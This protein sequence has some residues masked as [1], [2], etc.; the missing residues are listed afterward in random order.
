MSH[1]IYN[2][3]LDGEYGVVMASSS[4][5]RK[6]LMVVTTVKTHRFHITSKTS[7]KVLHNGQIVHVSDKIQLA[8]K[9]YNGIHSDRMPTDS[10]KSPCSKGG[11]QPLKEPIGTESAKEILCTSCDHQDHCNAYLRNPERRTVKCVSYKND[12][13][14]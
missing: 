4:G 8:I 11:I 2:K 9:H 12:S 1:Q 7:Y 5:E 3:Q 14:E 13:H 6:R 10:Y